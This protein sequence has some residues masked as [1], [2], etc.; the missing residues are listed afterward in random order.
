MQ[1]AGN[2]HLGPPLANKKPG[3]G[4][5]PKGR[6]RVPGLLA[7]YLTWLQAGRLKLTTG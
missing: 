2:G 7:I 5:L 1:I 6:V 4:N 3:R